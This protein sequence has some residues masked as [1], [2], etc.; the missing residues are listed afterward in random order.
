M[1]ILKGAREDQRWKEDQL[2]IRKLRPDAVHGF[3]ISW[4]DWEK[5][6]GKGLDHYSHQKE[7][8]NEGTDADK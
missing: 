8:N 1:E 3:D 6:F 7:V 5:I 2:G 4:E